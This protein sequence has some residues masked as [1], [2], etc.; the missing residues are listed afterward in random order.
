VKDVPRREVK[1]AEPAGDLGSLADQRRQDPEL[2]AYLFRLVDR[3]AGNPERVPR[4][5][6]AY[7]QSS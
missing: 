3:E 7:D 2:L 1:R 4:K 6:Q 5:P